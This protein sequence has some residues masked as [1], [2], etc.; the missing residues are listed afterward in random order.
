MFLKI[1]MLKVETYLSVFA[2]S[3]DICE[4]YFQADVS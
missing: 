3:L 2:I 4:E 1:N